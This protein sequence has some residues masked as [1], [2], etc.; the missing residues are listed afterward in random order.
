[1]TDTWTHSNQGPICSQGSYALD[2]GT[3]FEGTAFEVWCVN[4][5]RITGPLLYFIFNVHISF[6]LSDL[7][8]RRVSYP[9]R[10]RRE[11]AL[12]VT[13]PMKSESE[14]EKWLVGWLPMP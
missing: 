3:A 7:Q 11:A 13:D 6:W 5:T 2:P 9:D 12:S 10:L 1:M 4:V 14:P 8:M